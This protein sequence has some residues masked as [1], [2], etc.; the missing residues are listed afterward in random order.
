[1]NNNLINSIGSNNLNKKYYNTACLRVTDGNEFT[2]VYK[3]LIGFVKATITEEGCIEF[4]VA[5]S[6]I[7]NKEFM[8]WE[9]WEDSKYLDSHMQ[10]SH[11]QTILSKNLVSL[12]W[13]HS[14]DMKSL[15]INS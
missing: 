1:M 6:S 13:S 4:F 9:I 7:E 5:P 10:A 8:L 2:S 3:E 11:T 14:A 12:L 15:A